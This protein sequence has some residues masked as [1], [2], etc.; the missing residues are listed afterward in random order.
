MV[1]T[2]T[3]ETPRLRLR[4]FS[5]NDLEALLMIFSDFETNMYLPWFPISTLEEA[6]VILN[7]RYLETYMSQ[8]G[9]NYAICLKTDDIPIG[10]INVS[11]DESHDLG[12][13]L[14][15]K[16]WHKGIVTEAGKAILEQIKKDGIP[17][18]TATHDVKNLRSGEVMKHLGMHYQYSYEEL[19]KPKN[20]LV[21]FRMYQLNFDSQDTRVYRT[22]WNK[23]ALHFIETDI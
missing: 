5:E 9:Y 1:N 3:L 21:T 13:G 23:Y 2:P 14:R 7:T 4:K 6:R 8:E 12:Y 20:I 18:I 11:T 22:Y 17:Y 15:K 16:F 10:Y 19:W